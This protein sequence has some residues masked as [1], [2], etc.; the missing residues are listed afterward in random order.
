MSI[1]SRRSV[2]DPIDVVTGECYL[3]RIDFSLPGPIPLEWKAYYSSQLESNGPLGRR[4]IHSY[5]R[6]LT[7][8]ENRVIYTD[9][10][11][12]ATPFLSIPEIGE[13]VL[14]TDSRLSLQRGGE[15]SFNL[16]LADGLI[17]DF[18]GLPST[19]HAKLEKIF[20]L[21]GQKITLLYTT[22]GHLNRI[23][24][25]ANRILDLELDAR[26]RI[27]SI[28]CSTAG[29]RLAAY[30][31]DSAGNLISVT[32]ANGHPQR[33]EYDKDHQLLKRTDRNGYSFHYRYENNRCVKTRG[34]DGLYTGEFIYEPD[35]Q[36]TFQIGYDGRR[37]EY[38]YDKNGL[39]TEEVDP[40]GRIATTLYDPMGN[41][42]VITDRCG[43]STVYR[44]DDRGN[45]IEEMDPM[46]RTTTYSYNDRNQLLEKIEPRGERTANE[47][48]DRSNLVREELPD[49]NVI[50]HKYDD[51]GHRTFTWTSGQLPEKNEYD[52]SHQL[53]TIRN[54]L[55]GKE[56][57]KYNHDP[58]GNITGIWDDSGWI[59]YKY[60]GMSRLLEAEYPDGTIEKNTYDQ[61]G[62]VS[63]HTDRLGNIWQYHYKAREQMVEMIAPD[64]GVTKYDYTHA[65]ELC[66]VIDPN[67]NRTEYVYDLCD[68]IVEIRRNGS[69]CER[70]ERDSEGRL[71]AKR[72]ERGALLADLSFDVCDQPVI[73]VIERDGKK[74]ENHV[75]YDEHGQTV[76]ASNEYAE[77]ERD[78]DAAGLIVSEIANGQGVSHEY[79]EQGRL[80][81]TSFDDGVEFRLK[82]H[83]D[84]VAVRDP[85]GGWHAWHF[86]E[87]H[88]K[89]R[90]L[91][92]DVEESFDYD[93]EGRVTRHTVSKVKGS[94]NVHLDQQYAYDVLGHL[95]RLRD[96]GIERS[97]EYDDCERLTRVKITDPIIGSRDEESFT[98]DAG[99]NI[100]SYGN[101]P[102]GSVQSGNQLVNW[103]DRRFA[104]DDRGRLA[105]EARGQNKYW[106]NY[107]SSDQLV[108]V[109]LGGG[110]TAIYEYDALRR[111]VSKK[112]GDKRTIFGWD[113][114]RLS[115]EQSPGGD[116]RYYFY[117]GPNE[118][119]PVMFCDIKSR[120]DGEKTLET[121]FAH[122]D[123]ANRPVLITNSRGD[124][125]WSAEMTAYGKAGVNPDSTITYNLRAPGQYYDEETGFHYNYHRYY[126]PETGRYIQ[127]DP[128]G[129]AGG[130]NLYGYG[131]GN[132]LVVCDILGLLNR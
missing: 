5:H 11:G 127:P 78:Y 36:R 68:K 57:T 15:D 31:Y 102:V 12:S 17:L 47:Y 81:C 95:T 45:K 4:W 76:S 25:S 10:E 77:M 72:N 110:R 88:V 111:R 131:E 128:I 121:Y 94:Y 86:E 43:R 126:D 113:G 64:G 79:D 29:A 92:S 74:I 98:Y 120:S 8:D 112:V 129:L 124:A 70:Y 104:Y 46:G 2:L 34:D 106:F 7:F 16:V 60:D 122:Y 58:L 93:E 35:K 37:I 22:R 125:V 83:G 1:K 44:Y 67:G 20:N 116:R 41:I 84:A 73:R 13:I 99:G 54:P 103:D 108:S 65:D 109:E 118:Y 51:E 115:W 75:A 87:N 82:Y 107:D 39:V 30:D 123:Q 71:I 23:I 33:Y 52:R 114:D 100:I 21:N 9:G 3:E 101:G 14:S 66:Q 56:I 80:L 49:G 27:L 32:D 19:G 89:N 55:I 18:H 61:E 26:G 90:R 53:V 6:Y 132:P 62:N 85:G 24:D 97:F 130:L 105:Y 91:A 69:V 40:Y 59:R 119:S 50:T 28:T 117:A 38:R 63:S 96:R 48:D 42:A